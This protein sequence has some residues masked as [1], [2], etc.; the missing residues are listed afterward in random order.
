MR[1]WNLKTG[2]LVKDLDASAD[3]IAFNQDAKVI[4]LADGNR[5]V[6]RTFPDGDVVSELEVAIS[7]MSP[8]DYV[9]ACATSK[10]GKLLAIG[11]SGGNV[12]IWG[13]PAYAP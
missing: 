5:I 2:K 7:Y 13:V 11:D 10:D 1:I 3:C 12:N 6:F 4:I 9:T 8:T